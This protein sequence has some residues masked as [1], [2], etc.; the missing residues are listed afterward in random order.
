MVCRLVPDL[1]LEGLLSAC[2]AV[3]QINL[4]CRHVRLMI[5]GDGPARARWR[6]RRG[7]TPHRPRVIVLAGE[8]A[9]PRPGYAA[10]DIVIGQGGSP[11]GAWLSESRSW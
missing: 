4:T 9:E 7:Q 5:I 10:A 6:P 3:G 1:K 8:M 11:C 2:D